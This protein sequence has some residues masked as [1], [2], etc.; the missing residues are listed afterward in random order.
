MYVGDRLVGRVADGVF[1]SSQGTGTLAP[2]PSEPGP[3][4]SPQTGLHVSQTDLSISNNVSQS[5]PDSTPQINT[6]P[7]ISEVEATASE[8]S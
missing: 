8:S 5:A 7:S 6:P 3:V 2:S 4:L 1:I